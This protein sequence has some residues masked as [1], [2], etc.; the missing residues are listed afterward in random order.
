MKTTPHGDRSMMLRL[1]LVG[2][3]A[4]LGVTLPAQPECEK[5]FESV[6]TWAAATLA[7]WDTWK[8]GEEG[9]D[10]RPYARGQTDCPQCRLARARLAENTRD[11]LTTGPLPAVVK[12]S[13]DVPS[14]VKP[15]V[16]KSAES[17][18]RVATR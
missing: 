2:M 16:E 1:A 9:N 11:L 12:V 5:W 10:C 14:S 8:P 6:Q 18:S 3:V 17:A 15:A 13:Q 4:A 7:D